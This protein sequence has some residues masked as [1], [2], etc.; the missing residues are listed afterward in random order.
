MCDQGGCGRAAV[1]QQALDDAMQALESRV[2]AR[3]GAALAELDERISKTDMKVNGPV[4]AMLHTMA[5]EQIDLKA[6]LDASSASLLQALALDQMELKAKLDQSVAPLL[7]S[8]ALDQMELRAGLDAAAQPEPRHAAA[9]TPALDRGAP[10]SQADKA[11]LEPMLSPLKSP[12][13]VPSSLPA[14]SPSQRRIL[15][16]GEAETSNGAW[17][18]APPPAAA[19]GAGHAIWT[20]SSFAYSSKTPAWSLAGGPG[21][22][23]R[24]ARGGLRPGHRSLPQLPP[25]QSP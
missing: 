20:G 21:R 14:A 8:L 15:I 10:A 13:R 18:Y 9:A 4:A 24:P 23:S 22:L 1:S 6:R 16:A 5:Q 2:L 7:H 17:G 19:A 11:G 12:S 3:V 25:V